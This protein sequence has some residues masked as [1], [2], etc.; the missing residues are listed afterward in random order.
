[1]IQ[2]N[3]HHTDPEGILSLARVATQGQEKPAQAIMATMPERHDSLIDC[4][5]WQPR[6]KHAVRHPALKDCSCDIV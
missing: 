4:T 5:I 1:M 6:M 3:A 2:W